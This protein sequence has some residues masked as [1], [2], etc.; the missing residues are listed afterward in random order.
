MLSRGIREVPRPLG[1]NKLGHLAKRLS[2]VS[3]TDFEASMWYG[4][5]SV[6]TPDLTFTGQSPFLVH[7]A[8]V[9]IDNVMHSTIRRWKQRVLPIRRFI[10]RNLPWSRV[11]QP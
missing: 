2:N 9:E 1:P 5:M 6:S 7:G 3:L 11:V 4:P 8:V 10:W